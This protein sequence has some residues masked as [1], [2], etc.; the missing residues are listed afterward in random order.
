MP[1]DLPIRMEKKVNEKKICEV[2]KRFISKSNMARH[3]RTKR[4]LL[5][6]ET[7]NFF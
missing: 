6:V 4:H 3:E 1:Q 2:C 5:K 7:D